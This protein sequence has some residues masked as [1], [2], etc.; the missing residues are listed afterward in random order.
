MQNQKAR[1]LGLKAILMAPWLALSLSHANEP[2]F[3]PKAQ[4]DA[5]AGNIHT[6]RPRSVPRSPIEKSIHIDANSRYVLGSKTPYT[7]T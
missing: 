4:L 6:L 1:R 3:V 7:L 2:V 5:G